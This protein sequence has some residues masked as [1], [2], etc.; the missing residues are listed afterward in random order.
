MKIGRVA[1]GICFFLALGRTASA[2][3]ELSNFGHLA[4]EQRATEEKR[5]AAPRERK[6]VPAAIRSRDRPIDPQLQ[7]IWHPL[8]AQVAK[9]RDHA[10]LFLTRLTATW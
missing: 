7:H 8:A 4:G 6:N 9:S 3:A 1:F 2:D 10:D 5:A